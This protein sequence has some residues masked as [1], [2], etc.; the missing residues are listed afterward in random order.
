MAIA[1]KQRTT[2]KGARGAGQ[3]AS[4][5]KP[6]RQAKRLSSEKFLEAYNTMLSSRLLD[7]KCA[8]ILKQSKGGTF[9]ISGPGHEAVLA[10]ASMVF[11]SG[12]DWS[13]CHYRDQCYNLGLGVTPREIL[14]AFM[15]REGDP[16]SGSRQMPS[17]FGHKE[18]RIVSKSSCVGTQYLQAAG[19]GLACKQEGKGEVVYC[20]SGEGT[21]AE[22]E[23]YEALN[24][25][26]IH[27]CSTVFLVE[28]NGYAIS[29]PREEGT[30]SASIYEQTSGFEGL[31][32]F[33]VDGLDFEASYQVLKQAHERASKGL[34][35]SLIVADVI[36]LWGHSSSDNPAKYLD[37]QALKKITEQDPLKMF[38][39][40]LVKRK[41]ATKGEL[42]LLRTEIKS[43]IDQAASEVED[44]PFPSDATGHLY[45]EGEQSITSDRIPVA[46]KSGEPE[47]MVDLINRTLHEEMARNDKIVVFGQDVAK[48]KGGVFTAT[49]GLTEAFGDERCFNSPLAEATIAGIACGLAHD[50]KWKPVI[51]IQFGD[52]IF[53]AHQQIINELATC[54]YRSNGNWENSVVIRVPVGGYI[55][56]ALYHSQSID[57]IYAHRPGLRIAIPS[58]ADDAK[59]LLKAA[60]R[61]H[62]PV[63]FMEPK[64]LYRQARAKAEDPG[65]DYVLPFGKL[66]VVQS[67]SDITL[68]TWGNTVLWSLDAAKELQNKTGASVEILDLRTLNPW[69]KEGIL[70]SV[71]KTN[72]CVVV[73]EDF[74]TGGFGAEISAR[75]MEEAFDQLDAP[76][77]RV[78][79]KDCFCPYSKPLEN[80]ILPQS[81]DIFEALKNVLEY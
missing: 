22:G 31:E 33:R 45:Y 72:R 6:L 1:N 75:I 12:V 69:D 27:Q 43:G 80:Q 39:A 73:H 9:Q 71:R 21:T 29:T 20:S 49:T 64:F 67:G 70:E 57:G 58:R 81:S 32:K 10:A 44:V 55:Q 24:F 62:D 28:D 66:R 19:R 17:H 25:A 5:K 36:R 48:G 74:L 13:Y 60:I 11:R 2:K 47:V 42:E 23:F 7:E 40:L 18:H 46:E 26:A 68:V 30:A 38:E 41:Y 54:R 79:A 34:G 78:A 4:N 63:L 56:G 76:V 51:E 15:A 50:P 37:D 3:K 53:P 16:A 35:P 65:E 8:L 14:L 52:Y 77:L 61:G 59:G